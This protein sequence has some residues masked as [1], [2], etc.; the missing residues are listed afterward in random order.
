MHV[1]RLFAAAVVIDLAYQMIV[2]RWIYPGQ[3]LIVAATP[4]YFL[5]RGLA[6]RLVRRAGGPEDKRHAGGS[7]Y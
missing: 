2:F 1:R 7:T 6:N 5:M 4:A 3:A